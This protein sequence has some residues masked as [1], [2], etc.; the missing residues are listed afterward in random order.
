LIW[1]DTIRDHYEA[2]WR[3]K[4]EMCP[5]TAGPIGDLPPDFRV[6]R[7]APSPHREQWT[8]ATCGMSQPGDGK[9]VELYMV[10]PIESDAIVELLVVTAHFHRT[11]ARLDIGHTVNFGRAWLPGSACTHGQVSLLY[12]DGPDLEVIKIDAERANCYWL[13]PITPGEVAFKKRY[14]LEA[15][16]QKFD[17]EGLDYAN[18]QR[19]SVA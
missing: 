4:A 9:P 2:V 13:L 15:L 18:P 7:I 1:E 3:A 11:A 8:Y 16:E 19:R 6:V 5:F 17:Y 14:G 12:L 10:V